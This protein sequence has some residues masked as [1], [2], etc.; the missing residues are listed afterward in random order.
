MD[1]DEKV[2]RWIA[3][4][5]YPFMGPIIV[6]FVFSI[7]IKFVRI[8]IQLIVPLVNYLDIPLIAC[9]IMV[10]GR[11]RGGTVR[12]SAVRGGAVRWSAVRGGAVRWSAIS[13]GAVRRIGWR[14]RR[15]GW[16]LVG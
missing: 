10:S 7:K 6:C 13:R 11:I 3:K 4:Q 1:Y 2:P 16:G 15:I 14:I 12:W 8:V 9:S 5:L